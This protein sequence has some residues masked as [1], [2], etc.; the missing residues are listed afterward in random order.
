MVKSLPKVAISS[1]VFG[2]LCII[3]YIFRFFFHGPNMGS[4]FERFAVYMLAVGLI[5]VLNGTAVL[6]LY[7]RFE[8]S[9]PHCRKCGYSFKG[10]TVR[11]NC[12]AETSVQCPECGDVM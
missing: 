9:E 10:R 8:W 6:L 11:C 2:C 4:A 1:W 7:L 3:H 12:G 5:V